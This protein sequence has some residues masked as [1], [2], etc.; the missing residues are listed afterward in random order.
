M[1]RRL[2]V[3]RH[4]GGFDAVGWTLLGFLLGAS[5]AVFA[6]LHADMHGLMRAP[7]A[8]PVSA[9][10]PPAPSAEVVTTYAPPAPAALAAPPP[11]F[12][13]PATPAPPT[14]PL[15]VKPAPVVNALAS[16]GAASA[17]GD[18]RRPPPP[19]ASADPPRIAASSASPASP[20]FEDDAAAA[21]MT[22]RAGRAPPHVQAAT[23]VPSDLY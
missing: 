23:P 13:Q 2:A 16:A 11:V 8:A 7:A 19:T 6:L 21:G 15:P 18:G 14:A 17:R 4:A 1:P 22:S 5:L 20:E 10:P 3:A 12:L 9:G